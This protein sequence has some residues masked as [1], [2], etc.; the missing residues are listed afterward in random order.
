MLAASYPGERV[1]SR[2]TLRIT[3]IV[4][5]YPPA[6]RAG[7]EQYTH[8]VAR[9]M[10]AQ[11]HDVEVVTLE[12][13]SEGS[14]A[15]IESTLETY[16]NVP[17]H[18]LR[19]KLVGAPHE[20][21][22]RFDNPLLEQWV[23]DYLTE[24]KPDFVHFMAGYL[25][26]I[27]PLRAVRAARIPMALTMH[28]YWFVCPRHTLQRGNGELCTSV[29]EAPSACARCVAQGLDRTAKVDTIT[30]GLYSAVLARFGL[31]AESAAIAQR[32]AATADAI[33][34][35]DVVIAPTR[36]LA[37]KIKENLPRADVLVLPHGNDAL[38]AP[39]DGYAAAAN[40]RA[41]GVQ[42]GYMGQI[43]QHKGVHVLVEAFRRLDP[44]L[45]SLHV[46]G[47]LEN[48]PAYTAVLRKLAGNA[49]NI[50]FHGGYSRTELPV[51]LAGLDAVVVPS[52]WYENSPLVIMEALGEGVPVITSRLG[53][54]AEL[55]EDGR[56]GLHFSVGDADALADVLRTLASDAEL[57]AHLRANARR[58]GRGSVADEMQQ[59]EAIYS[60]HA[61]AREQAAA[62]SAHVEARDTTQAAA[63]VLHAHRD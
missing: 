50:H 48:N 6:Y 30:G 42:F 26:G 41:Q 54:M 27:G 45:A 25:I 58:N 20:L 21:T 2:K 24:R 12:S 52:I 16:E 14:S 61:A 8:R 44:E 36:F 11:G 4:H 18:R 63:E 31:A 60:T 55:V 22:W 43:A 46:H 1:P 37:G 32:R 10:V 53:G 59:L 3:Y 47:V 51:V 9:W 23:A 15:R 28:D 39:A 33:T 62:G 49:P 19:F 29:P 17:V 7:A 5:H 13:I 57:R 38:P 34:W 35:P 40:A 56:T